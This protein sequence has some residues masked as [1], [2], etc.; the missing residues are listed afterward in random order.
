MVKD[1]KNVSFEDL[2]LSEDILNAVKSAGYEKPSPIQAQAIPAILEGRD[3]FGCAQTG[4]GKTAAFALPIMQKLE[5]G[6]HYP[7]PKQFRALILAPTRELAEQISSNIAVY[8][9]ALKL[10]H[11]KVYGGVSQNPQVKALAAGQDIVIATPGRLLDLF[12][13][14]K[15]SFEGVEYLV[16][17]EADRML[18]MGFLPDIRKICSQLPAKRQSL[19]FS[20]TL[21]PE[22]QLLAQSIVVN[23]QKI[24][25]SPDKPTVDKI[26]QRVCFVES[27]NKLNLLEHILREHM[28]DDD[29]A[30][31]LI[32]TRT[33][34]G[35]NKLAKK[36]SSMGIEA[37]AIHGNK[38]QSARQGAL[39]RFKQR[40][41]RVLVATDIAAR[42]IDVK[43]MTLVINY[44]MPE[45][46][47]TYVHRIGRTAR[48]E[49]NGEAVSFCSPQ[50]VSLLRAVEKF[51]KK[52]LHLSLDNP[53]H[54]QIAA[55]MMA[56][57][58]GKVADYQRPSAV[59]PQRRQG[60]GQGNGRRRSADDSFRPSKPSR[61][62]KGR[63]GQSGEG[64][65][66]SRSKPS[67]SRGAGSKPS[68]ESR[69]K[70]KGKKPGFW[71]K[72]KAKAF[73]KK[74]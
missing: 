5:S 27:E 23:P 11:C 61:K 35:T 60:G 41:S 71:E 70:A 18:D 63:G 26:A 51:I 68:G 17:D 38:S 15:L 46:A 2:H 47:E 58:R 37:D 32:F 43:D 31:A 19:L 7:K 25:I 24:M 55:D 3:I 64:Q 4:T 42:G 44:D 65:K 22:I 12:K 33:K 67:S 39:N 52:S 14:K 45:E 57:K 69:G 28:Q 21:S 74:A 6:G 59:K 40:E 16:L 56:G 34:H 9:K 62:P 20:A 8:G 48:A 49:K 1:T 72:M 73:G 13:Q 36:L 53:F 10:S 54:S 29:D 50:E 66:P 30:I